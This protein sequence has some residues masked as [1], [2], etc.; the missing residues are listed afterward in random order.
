VSF[1][2]S[3]LV[4]KKVVNHHVWLQLAEL[5][6]TMVTKEEN[7]LITEDTLSKLI[8][9]DK[10]IHLNQQPETSSFFLL[11]TA[12]FNAFLRREQTTV[13]QKYL[14]TVTFDQAI[15]IQELMQLSDQNQWE[16]AVIKYL[17]TD[18]IL[19]LSNK[20]DYSAEFMVKLVNLLI[21]DPESSKHQI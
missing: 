16:I 14:I 7:L 6:S 1:A 5:W 4:L 8:N 19:K 9:N 2:S 15:I 18:L 11:I 21:N 12:K 17:Q 10:K 3:S 13:P 20:H